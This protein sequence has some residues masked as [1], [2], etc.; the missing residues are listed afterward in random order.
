MG[1]RGGESG[2]EESQHQPGRLHTHHHTPLYTT[3]LSLYL[4]ARVIVNTVLVHTLYRAGQLITST[5]LYRSCA[6]LA[7]FSGTF[8]LILFEAVNLEYIVKK[9]KFGLVWINRQNKWFFVW[10]G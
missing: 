10:F 6:A 1:W 2:S 8:D 7:N 5:G 9:V 4:P 3:A